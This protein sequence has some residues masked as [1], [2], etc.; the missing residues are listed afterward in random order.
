MVTT[1]ACDPARAA[2]GIKTS[3]ETITAKTT[4]LME[5]LLAIDNRVYF[6]TRGKCNR[7]YH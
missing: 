7:R 6:R 1:P 4:L 5:L 2:E 3:E